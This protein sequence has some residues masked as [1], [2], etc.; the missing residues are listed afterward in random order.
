M[1]AF[2]TDT[3]LTL[4]LTHPHTTP[5][6]TV[7]VNKLSAMSNSVIKKQETILAIRQRELNAKNRNLFEELAFLLADEHGVPI[8]SVGKC[9]GPGILPKAI[10]RINAMI[11]ATKTTKT[12]SKTTA[13]TITKTAASTITKTAAKTATKT[14]TKKKNKKVTGTV[15]EQDVVNLEDATVYWD[16]SAARAAPTR[17]AR[18]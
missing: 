9:Y 2:F 18:V 13:S 6:F 17:R 15:T 14:T 12:A 1:L 16:R 3:T 10:E 8:Q 5:H 4:T 11:T 7:A